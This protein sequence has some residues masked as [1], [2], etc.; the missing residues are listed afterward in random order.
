MSNE[1]PPQ[2]SSTWS[3]P[4]VIA[5]VIGGVVT[6]IVAIV[7]ILPTIIDNR[8]EEPTVVVVTA[9][10]QPTSAPEVV[11]ASDTTSAQ[12]TLTPIVLDASPQPTVPID[13]ASL[14]QGNVLLMYD[15]VSFTLR[16]QGTD[17]LSLSGVVFQSTNGYWEARDWGP[18][19]YVSVPEGECLRLRDQMAGNRNPPAACR[20]ENLYGLQ[21]VGSNAFFWLGV[22]SFD[23]MKN[24]QVIATCPTSQET[25]LIGV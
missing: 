21:L 12:A 10:P 25:C 15:D 1:L 5:A 16:N 20:G 24:G 2:Q 13:I 6:I 23:V 11:P 14:N 17:I 19:V 8:A 9:T 4:Q 7:G 3:N 22:E 18:S